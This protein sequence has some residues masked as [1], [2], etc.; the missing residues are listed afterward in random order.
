MKKEAGRLSRRGFLRIAAAGG[1]GVAVGCSESPNTL[2][3]VRIPEPLR[4]GPTS[5]E[6][7]SFSAPDGDEINPVSHCL[8]RLTFG[9]APGDYDRVLAMGDIGRSQPSTVP[10]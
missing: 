7:S 5:E 6:L 9:A 8:N 1:G 2:F 4:F 3:G 10:L